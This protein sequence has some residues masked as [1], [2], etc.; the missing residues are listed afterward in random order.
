MGMT[1]P[2][3]W[4]AKWIG[5]NRM[6]RRDVDFGDARWIAGGQ[7]TGTFVWDGSSGPCDLVYSC[8]RPHRVL[9]NG[10]EFSV[11]AG[12]VYDHRHL[13]FRDLRTFLMKGTNTI[14]F[15]LTPEKFPRIQQENPPEEIATL[16]LIRL[17]GGVRCVSDASWSG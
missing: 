10:R 14:S 13:R 4:Q 1:D 7:V 8:T 11:S 12:M 5:P 6:T 9:L 17:P 3:G 16:A 2:N 15:A